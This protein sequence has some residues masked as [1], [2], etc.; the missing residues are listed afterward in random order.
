[1]SEQIS[2]AG[3]EASGTGNMKLALN[4][5]L[6]IGTRDGANIEIGEAVGEENIF[7]FG[8]TA[9]E[10]ANRRRGGYDPR[11]LYASDDELRRVLDTIRD[12][13]FRPADDA[14]ITIVDS[15]IDGGDHYMLL[16][17]F[18]AYL[19]TQ[20]AVDAAYVDR[21]GWTRKAIVNVAKMGRFSSDRTVR[22]YAS[23][24]WRVAPF[25]LLPTEDGAA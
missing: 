5:A 6:T 4:G 9:E 15:L 19:E 25:C 18:R 2:T 20:L 1:V 8:L 13:A 23:E 12:G 22:E 16:A 3:A 10:V 7:F 24:I 17:D 14:H 21:D 11:V